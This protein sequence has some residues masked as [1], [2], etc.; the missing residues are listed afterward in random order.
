[1][2]LTAVKIVFWIFMTICTAG[3]QYIILHFNVNYNLEVLKWD[4][5]IMLT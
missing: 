2:E 4:Y 3:A 1:M 5:W